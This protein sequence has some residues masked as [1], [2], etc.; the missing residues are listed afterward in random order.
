MGKPC[1]SS[2]NKLFSTY[3]Y[4][5]SA[6]TICTFDHHVKNCLGWACTI[7]LWQWPRTTLVMSVSNQHELCRPSILAL[8]IFGTNMVSHESIILL[9]IL[10]I[11]SSTILNQHAFLDGWNGSGPRLAKNLKVRGC[12]NVAFCHGLPAL[13]HDNLTDTSENLP[14]GYDR[15]WWRL[16]MMEAPIT[17]SPLDHMPFCAKGNVERKICVLLSFIMW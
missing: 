17:C 4:H 14:A 8:V 16:G 7:W 10:K 5:M 12:Q 9:K 1:T 6:R 11:Y 3:R 13:W 15:S 2:W